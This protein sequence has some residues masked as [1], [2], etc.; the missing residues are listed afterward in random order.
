MP[1]RLRHR[2][3]VAAHVVG[4]A[5]RLSGGIGLEQETPRLVVGI[6]FRQVLPA[7]ALPLVDGAEARRFEAIR[8]EILQA[9]LYLSMP[10]DLSER[11]ASI[12]E[13]PQQ[14]QTTTPAGRRAVRG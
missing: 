7:L 4:V 6:P 5:C 13:P 11:I 12:A 1:H 2:K 3:D 8:V 14:A 9:Y 10:C